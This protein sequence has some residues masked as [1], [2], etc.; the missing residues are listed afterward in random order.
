MKKS[1]LSSILAAIALSLSV[2]SAPALADSTSWM[3]G[4][5]SAGNYVS[6]GNGGFSAAFTGG[7]GS[8]SWSGNTDVMASGGTAGMT[9]G[10]GMTSGYVNAGSVA[11]EN[12]YYG[13]SVSSGS[14]VG[15]TAYSYGGVSMSDAAANASGTAV[16]NCYYCW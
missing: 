9:D 16:N 15:T 13:T 11:S 4:N 1:I 14:S 10:S 5:V 6:S 2:A 7:A 8:N 12:W 3:N